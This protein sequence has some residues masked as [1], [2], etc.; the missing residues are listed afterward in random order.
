MWYEGEVVERNGDQNPVAQRS[1]V[2]EYQVRLG[3][4]PFLTKI[5]FLSAPLPLEKLT[6]LTGHI[7][8]I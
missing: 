8:A 1:F 7:E 3:L 5:A 6:F 4:L 2:E